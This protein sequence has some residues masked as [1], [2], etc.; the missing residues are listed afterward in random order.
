MSA[1]AIALDLAFLVAAVGIC[2]WLLVRGSAFRRDKL[3]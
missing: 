2:A 3:S 1:A